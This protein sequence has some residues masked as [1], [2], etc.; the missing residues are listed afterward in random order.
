[1]M[2]D[3]CNSVVEAV[4]ALP[5]ADQAGS[6]STQSSPGALQVEDLVPSAS[7]ISFDSSGQ[8]VMVCASDEAAEAGLCW[9]SLSARD[10]KNALVGCQHKTV[11]SMQTSGRRRKFPTANEMV[12]RVSVRRDWLEPCPS[13]S[14]SV[15]VCDDDE[16]LGT[17]RDGGC[18]AR[19]RGGDLCAC[20]EYLGG[21][22]AFERVDDGRN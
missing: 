16:E 7:V 10:V 8:R 13:L 22:L 1:M 21:P 14:R 18:R 20:G 2:L 5:S 19:R 11:M 15:D 9:A 12:L 3:A 4:D 6:L 17:A